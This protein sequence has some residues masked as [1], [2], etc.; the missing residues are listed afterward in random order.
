MVRP[1]QVVAQQ[2]W[3]LVHIYDQNIQIAVV[4]D[5]TECAAAARMRRG[6]TRTG[7]GNLF[8]GA[9]AKVPE[10]KSGRLVRVLRQE[11]LNLRVDASGDQEDVRPAIIV[12]VYNP[13]SP[14]GIAGLDTQF[15]R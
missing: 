3:R 12:E 6:H 7:I 2:R 14:T 15:R 11:L 9:V 8:E 5:I 1:F 13:R 4:V 10:Q